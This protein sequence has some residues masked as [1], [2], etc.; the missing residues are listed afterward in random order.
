MYGSSFQL[1]QSLQ[2]KTLTHSSHKAI[3]S[4]EKTMLAIFLTILL[5]AITTTAFAS[6]KPPPGVMRER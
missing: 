6:P 3:T 4:A 1:E 2:S 5:A